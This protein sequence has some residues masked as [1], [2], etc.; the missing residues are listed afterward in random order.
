[1]ET[2]DE[3]HD[4]EVKSSTDVLLVDKKSASKPAVTPDLSVEI[5]LSV[6]RLKGE[7]VNCRRI[8]GDNYRCNWLALDG[9]S[10]Q[11]GLSLALESYRVRDSKFL[12]VKKVGEQLVIE[13]VTVQESGTN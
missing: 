9:R 5:A 3:S 2:H 4:T 12:R 11:R 10:G 1:M 8:Y 6:E 13:D 7:K